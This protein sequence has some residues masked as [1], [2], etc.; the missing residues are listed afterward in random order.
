MQ[1]TAQHIWKK[2]IYY[3]FVVSRVHVVGDD[4]VVKAYESLFLYY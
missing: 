4:S 3:E 1:I 2:T